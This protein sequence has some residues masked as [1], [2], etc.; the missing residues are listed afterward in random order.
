ME[1]KSS[2]LLLMRN[3]NLFVRYDEIKSR[4]D[5]KQVYTQSNIKINIIDFKTVSFLQFRYNYI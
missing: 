5:C 3:L 4:F 1:K 2:N